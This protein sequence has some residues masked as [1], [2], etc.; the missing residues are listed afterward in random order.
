M[1]IFFGGILLGGLLLAAAGMALSGDRSSGLAPVGNDLYARECGSCHF[2]Y[3]PG[4]LPA[5]SWEK[6]MSTLSDHFGDNAELASGDAAMI[7]DYL[8]KNAADRSPSGHSARIVRSLKGREAPLRISEVPFIRRQHN[9]LP[10]RMV[11][12][13][14]KVKSLSNCGACHTGAD[15]GS[16]NED[17]ISIPGYGRWDD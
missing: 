6:I 17:G 10:S 16:Y 14:P 3:Q 8:V 9:E 13:N 1:K 11:T 2:A 15:R 4:L 12:G 7:R 5:A